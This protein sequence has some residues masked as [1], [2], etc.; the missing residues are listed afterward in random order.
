MAIISAKVNEL[1]GAI[2]YILVKYSAL[3]NTIELRQKTVWIQIPDTFYFLIILTFE[4]VGLLQ[5]I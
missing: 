1:T 2:S 5:H 3:I 4:K